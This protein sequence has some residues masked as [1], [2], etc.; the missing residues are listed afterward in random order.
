MRESIKN[1]LF[2]IIISII[3]FLFFSFYILVDT[4]DKYPKPDCIDHLIPIL[5]HWLNWY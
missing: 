4:C 1:F 2:I 3:I 5:F